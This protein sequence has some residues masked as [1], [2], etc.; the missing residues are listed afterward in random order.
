M[1]N[2]LYWLPPPEEREEKSLYF[3]RYCI[4]EFLNWEGRQYSQ[5]VG[6]E[7]IPYLKGLLTAY[8]QEPSRPD[9]WN[10]P[11]KK[12]QE[13]QSLIDGIERYGRVELSLHS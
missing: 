9:D 4:P 7:I 5:M 1:S 3:L 13:V 6:I 10:G 2:C 8:Q 12:I 11:H